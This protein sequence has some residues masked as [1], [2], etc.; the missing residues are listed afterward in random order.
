MDNQKIK[1]VAI[2][3]AGA[4]GTA[5]AAIFSAAPDFSVYFVARDERYRRLDGVPLVVN[6]QSFSIPVKRPKEIEKPA[7][8]VLVALKHHHLAAALGDIQ[9]AVGDQTIILSVMNGLESERIIGEVC[10]MEKVPLAI[11]VGIDAVREQGRTTYASPGRIIFGK[12]AQTIDDSRLAGLREAL[13]RAAIPCE[14]AGDMQRVMWW[15]FM[16]NVG[17]NQASAVMRAPYGVFQA[18]SDAR[19]LMRMLIQEVLMLADRLA[20]G[21][22]AVDLDAWMDVLGALSPQGKTS[23]LQDIEAGRKTEVEVFAGKV[24]SLGREHG[25]PTPVNEAVLHILKVIEARS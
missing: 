2:V 19:E 23:M 20:V 11:A 24:V 8:L 4:M 17:I 21:L 14:V 18:S 25:L 12:G 22:T 6:G 13:E 9:A 3:G 5:Y 1:T 7:D 15:K 16:I 10:G